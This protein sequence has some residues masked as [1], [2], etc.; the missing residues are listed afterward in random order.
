MTK[1]PIDKSALP[2]RPCVGLMLANRDGL[3]F[4]GR[5][6][7]RPNSEP[8]AWQM[9]QG[10][11]DPG[12]DEAVAAMRE[13]GEETGIVPAHADIIARSAEEHVYDLPDD[14]IGKLWGGKYRGQSQRWFLLRFKGEDRDI[15]IEA[16][17]PPEFDAWQWVE[18]EQLVELIVPFKR[19]LYRKVV[20]EF[21]PLL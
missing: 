11:V 5:R 18:A 20:E 15:D 3:V 10:G 13:L 16:H 4:V 12:E 19:T 14:L 7:D 9:P 17:R 21:R 8:D 1:H 6:I 2:Y